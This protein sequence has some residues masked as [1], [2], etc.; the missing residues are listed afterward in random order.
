[1]DQRI[2]AEQTQVCPQCGRHCPAD[3]LQCG[4]GRA[5]FGES[6]ADD[7]HDGEGRHHHGHG[8]GH[9]HHHGHDHSH[10]GGHDHYHASGMEWGDLAEKFERCGRRISHCLG[11]QRGQGKILRTLCQRGEM[12]QKELQELLGI[13]AGSMSEIAAKLEAKGLIVRVRSE[14]DRRKV[15][16]SITEQGRA[17]VAQSDASEIRRR[18]TELF[19]SL[20]AEEQNT[21]EALLD[22]LSANWGQRSEQ[23]GRS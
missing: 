3:A 20:T 1:M 19:S 10:G 12:P 5:Y 11:K 6:G 14:T 17:W 7:D 18:R 15:S 21:L 2:E 16:L 4:R 8:D 22:K 23:Q 13:Q 9:D